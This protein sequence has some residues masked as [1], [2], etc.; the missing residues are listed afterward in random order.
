MKI[1]FVIGAGFFLIGWIVSLVSA[2][3]TVFDVRD[4][5]LGHASK[6]RLFGGLSILIGIILTAISSLYFIYK[7]LP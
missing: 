5:I 2:P 4:E 1:V 3:T 7:V 6:P